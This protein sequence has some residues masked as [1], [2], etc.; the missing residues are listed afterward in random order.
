[1]HFRLQRNASKRCEQDF[2]VY[3][4]CQL[5]IMYNGRRKGVCVSAIMCYCFSVSTI[6]VTMT[7]TPMGHT[8]HTHTSVHILCDVTI[9]GVVSNITGYTIT[10]QWLGSTP[11][12]AGPEYTIT[13][14]TLRINQLSIARDNNRKITC[15]AVLTLSSGAKYVQQENIVLTVEGRY[16]LHTYTVY[17]PHSFIVIV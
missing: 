15:V 13:N 12:T 5:A 11:I 1:M 17:M 16:Y 8:L 2:T 7:T 9:V 3:F 6:N 10:R 14:N 4:M